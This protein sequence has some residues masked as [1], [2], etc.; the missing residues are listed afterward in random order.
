MRVKIGNED[1][2]VG[3]VMGF[4]CFVEELGLFSF[5]LEGVEL[6]MCYYLGCVILL[7]LS[8]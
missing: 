1:L 8:F 7:V 6:G 4:E 2:R 3:T 5:L